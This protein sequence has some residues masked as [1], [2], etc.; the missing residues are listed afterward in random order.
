DERPD[1]ALRAAKYLC[2]NGALDEAG[3]LIDGIRSTHGNRLDAA[4]RR[5][6]LDLRARLAVA[7]GA[8][9]EEAKVLQEILAL[10]PM[11]GDALILLGQ[12]YARNGKV[13]E[14]VFQYER[15]AGMEAFE[16]NAKV[17]H[18]Q[19]LV[20]AGRYREALPLLRRAQALEPREN[21]REYLEQ[22]ERR[23]EEHTSELQSRENL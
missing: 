20:G 8:G 10:D 2:A 21:V 9:E 22:V 19:L 16:A 17:R 12:H 23:S 7:S 3:V 15:A 5:A 6:L 13:E 14:A 11:D 4:D 18:A 1:R